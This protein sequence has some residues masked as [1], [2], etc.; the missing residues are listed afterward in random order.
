MIF[1][2]LVPGSGDEEALAGATAKT[3]GSRGLPEFVDK[4]SRPGDG[5]NRWIVQ[6]CIDELIY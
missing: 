4:T 3:H 1:D 6:R 2:S 5:S